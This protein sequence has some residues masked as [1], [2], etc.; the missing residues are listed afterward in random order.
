[1]GVISSIKISR[2]ELDNGFI[3]ANHVMV[4]SDMTV[5]GKKTKAGIVYGFD[6]DIQ[7]EGDGNSWESDIADVHG[8]VYKVP[9]ELYY[10]KED[11]SNSMS[12]LTEMEVQVGDAVWFSPI[13]SRNA[14]ALECEGKY[15]KIIPYSDCIC[16]RRKHTAWL[17]TF[18]HHQPHVDPWDEVVCLNGRVL[19]EFYNK[20]KSSSL[21]I[22]E[23]IDTTKGIVRFYGV[24]NKEYLRDEYIDFQTL[25][26]G[27]LILLQPGT[28]QVPLERRAFNSHFNNGK[29][30]FVT[31]RR[32]IAMIL[33]KNN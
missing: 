19:L 14:T 28:P 9:L 18:G 20:P 16:L 24:P 1:M 13:E 32:R 11:Q 30:Y 2:A 26:E 27:D 4:E 7:F 31:Q 33:S 12:W 22:K 3:P 5:Y 25:D 10:N 8:I 23:E 6:E 15:Y 29:M 17:D 21:D